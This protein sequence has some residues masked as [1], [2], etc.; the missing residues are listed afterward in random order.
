VFPL[1]PDLAFERVYKGAVCGIDEVGRG[2]LAGPVVAA[3]V[4][5]PHNLPAFLED[6]LDD[7]KRLAPAKREALCAAVRKC[8]RVGL[9]QATVEE[10]DRVNILRAT[11]LAMARAYAD[12]NEEVVCALVDGNQPPPLPCPV[13]CIVKGDGLSLSIAAASVVAKVTRDALMRELAG[14]FPGYGW[15]SNAG[16]GTKAHLD[17]LERLGPTSQHR[18]S[19]APV[20]RLLA[21]PGFVLE[22]ENL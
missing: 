1:P 9:G 2:P 11:F 17:A 10:I 8:A 20:A 7:S 16:Y 21:L 15:E 18:R 12:L 3:A 4:V 19:F 13:R 14:A 5:L 22:P 6:E